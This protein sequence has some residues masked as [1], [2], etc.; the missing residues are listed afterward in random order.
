M[1]VL[2]YRTALF[3]A[4]ACFAGLV[5]TGVLAYLIP[6]SHAHDSGA[7]AGFEALNRPRVT[8]LLTHVAHLA[9]FWPYLAIGLSLAVVAALRKRPRVAGAILLLLVATGATT[10][11]LKPLLAH[12]RTSEWLGNSRVTAASWPSGHATAAMTLALCA[13]MAATPRSRATVATIGALFAV[14]VSYAIL[15]LGWHFPSDVVGGYFVAATWTLL[16]VAALIRWPGEARARTSGEF[17]S[18]GPVIVAGATA[19]LAGLVVLARPQKVAD[20]V[21]QR[22]SFVIGASV[23]ALL[24]AAMAVGFARVLRS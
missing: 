20:F 2:S 9:D 19:G 18:R 16:A 3:A 5:A 1:R 11:L 14:A 23:I 12:P 22:P 21:L 6:V 24:A 13:V 15:A 7:L 4:L 17:D 8:S 10:A